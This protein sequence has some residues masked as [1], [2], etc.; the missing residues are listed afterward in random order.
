LTSPSTAGR[1]GLAGGYSQSSFRSPSIAASG[2]SD[3]YHVALYGGGQV[4]A[5][6]LRGGASFSWNDIIT[7]RQVAVVN[8]AE[9]Q[10]GDYA[11]KTTQVFGEVGHTY[12]LKAGALEPFANIAYVR[13]DGGVYEVGMAAMGPDRRSSIPPT[14]PSV[15]VARRR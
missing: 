7:T 10:R 15:C 9:T 14:R 1:V 3:S 5:W 12:G 6:G 8:L 4:G 11:L 13:V 2:S